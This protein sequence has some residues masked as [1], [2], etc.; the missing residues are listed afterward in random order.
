MLHHWDLLAGS[1]CFA[2]EIHMETHSHLYRI[3]L[4][5]ASY[6]RVICVM[7]SRVLRQ[8]AWYSASS[9]ERGQPRGKWLFGRE[10]E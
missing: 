2:G 3:T 10:A 4:Q 1:F 5:S 6:Y 7:L 9:Q 8:I